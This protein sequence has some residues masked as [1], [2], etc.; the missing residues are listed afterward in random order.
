MVEAEE[1][2]PQNLGQAF[3][4][5]THP[6]TCLEVRKTNQQRGFNH[7]QMWE[8]KGLRVNRIL[9]GTRMKVSQE[10]CNFQVLGL[11]IL[12]K[13]LEVKIFRCPAQP[14]ASL[15]TGQCCLYFVVVTSVSRLSVHEGLP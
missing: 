14:G 5:K 8:M 7:T 11:C 6:Q 2:E 15:G 4:K 12:S 1:E 13:N 3:F 9:R 10:K